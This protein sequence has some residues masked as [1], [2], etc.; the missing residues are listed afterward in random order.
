MVSTRVRRRRCI[1]GAQQNR[2]PL[3]ISDVVLDGG[4]QHARVE[5]EALV[6]LGCLDDVPTHRSQELS[7]NSVICEQP[8]MLRVCIVCVCVSVCVCV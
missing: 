4:D 7:G 8:V 1:L 3:L 2:Q 5:E 6:P